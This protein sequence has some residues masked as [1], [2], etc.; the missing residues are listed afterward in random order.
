MIT[1]AVL[2]MGETFNWPCASRIVAN[3]FPPS[4]R[5]LASGIFNSGAA[6][7]SL[8]APLLIGGLIAQRFGWR[9][10]FFTMGA[11]G[12][13]WLMLWVGATRRG[14]PC[15]QAVE[16]GPHYSLLAG[17]RSIAPFPGSGRRSL[18]AAV[19]LYG[20][21]L[22]APFRGSVVGICETSPWLLPVLF[23]G[24]CLGVGGHA[25]FGADPL[26][27][28]GRRLWNAD[29]RAVTVNPCW[30]FVNDWLMKY[31]REYRQLDVKTAAFIATVVFLVADLGN[32]VSGGVIKY[33]VAQ[34]LVVACRPTPGDGGH[35]RHGFTGDVADEGLQHAGHRGAV[36]DGGH[37]ADGDY[38]QFHG[39]PAGL[40]V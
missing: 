36:R 24:L 3:T 19:I 29:G 28:A 32:V 22:I 17:R 33:L 14:G 13:L 15:R 18:P 5:S 37:G 39:L 38:R 34:R 27:L 30:Y 31:L 1:R 23:W 12:F 10:A 11:L 2:G 20:P 16:N 21:R 35:R 6:L 25:A 7:G 4:D 40:R 9:A 26:A 8:I